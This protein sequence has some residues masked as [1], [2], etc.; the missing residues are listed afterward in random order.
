MDR[1]ADP[2]PIGH[3][4]G[5][6][7]TDASSERPAFESTIQRLVMINRTSALAFALVAL[8][9]AGCDDILSVENPGAIQE[10]QLTD[11][12]MEELIVNGVRGE[13]QYTHS[14]TSLYTGM[15]TDELMGNHTYFPTIPVF[16]RTIEPDNVYVANVYSFWQRARQSADDAIVRLEEILGADAASS[17]NVAQVHAYGGYSYLLIGETFC[18]APVNMSRAYSSEELF[19]MAL[20]HFDSAIATAEAARNAGQ[21]ASEASR[22]INLANVGAARTLLNLGRMD[23]AITYASRVEEGFEAWIRHSENSARE[24][25]PFYD[26]TTGA[27][28]RYLSVGDR[29]AESEDPRIPH[30]YERETS[31]TP[32]LVYTPYRPY[33]FEGWDDGAWTQDSVL[34]PIARDTDIRFAS[35]LEA[36]YIIAEAQG[37]GGTALDLVN[38]RREFA[39]QDPVSLSGDELM[40]EL[41]AQRAR[42]FYLTGRRLGDLRRYKNLYG[43][44]LFPTGIDP[45]RDE[46][47]GDVECFPIPLAELNA[48]PNL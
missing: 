26:P 10:D 11:P 34:V 15:F 13:F 27:N 44:D 14:Y 38:E 2:P 31:L 12:A 33:S 36:R 43:V 6:L 21:S 16:L 29:F 20:D 30:S 24:Y 25:N 7:L 4:A 47:Y 35:H 46:L 23:E 37:P 41:R 40:A 48:N 42:D 1:A 22:I 45:F 5:G 3:V 8:V 18:E 32:S 39:G 28:N 9:L 17:M 19:E